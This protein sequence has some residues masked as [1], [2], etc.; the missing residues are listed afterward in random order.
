MKKTRFI[1][2]L[3]CMVLCMPVGMSVS[4][5]TGYFNEYNSVYEAKDSNGCSS[6]QGM[7]IDRKENKLYYIKKDNKDTKAVISCLDLSKEKVTKTELKYKTKKGKKTSKTSTISGLVHANDM[8]FVRI[9][10]T[11]YLYV[12]TISEKSYQLVKLKVNGKTYETVA[13]YKVYGTEKK[14]GKKVTKKIAVSGISLIGET[15]ENLIFMM[16]KGSKIYKA[17]VGKNLG[18][19]KSVNLSSGCTLKLKESKIKG[20]KISNIGKYLSQGLTY[21]EGKVF[22]PY[23]NENVSVIFVFSIDGNQDL[24]KEVVGDSNLS[25]RI[26][27]KAFSMF[28]IESCAIA[29]DGKLYFNCNTNGTD[30]IAYFKNKSNVFTF[31][32]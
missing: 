21:Y 22:V 23:T 25:F 28:E 15:D 30:R 16:K 20:K 1:V 4:A 5:Q 8:E 2:I 14:D 26:T 9:G 13:S 3:L 7:C 18:N 31:G 19:K 17:T 29:A 12:V 11:S 6:M 24:P 27:S 32:A 10:N